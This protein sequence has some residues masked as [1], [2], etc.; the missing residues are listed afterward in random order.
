MANFKSI[1][2]GTDV[3][4]Q[5]LEKYHDELTSLTPKLNKCLLS[6]RVKGQGACF[7]DFEGEVVYCLIREYRPGIVYEISPDCGYSANYLL[8]AIKANEHGKLYSFEIETSKYNIPTEDIILGNLMISPND[9][10]FEL[11][12]GDASETVKNYPDPDFVLIDSCHDA[13]FAE[14]YVKELLP[15]IKMAALVQDIHFWDRPEYS[16]ESSFLLQHMQDSKKP[17]LA[18]GMAERLPMIASVRQ[19]FVPR[20][21][22][23]TNSILLGFGLKVENMLPLPSN[24]LGN[25][26]FDAIMSDAE[27]AKTYNHING[28]PKRPNAHRGYLYLAKVFKSRENH[29]EVSRYLQMVLGAAMA[30]FST[31][32]GKG[33]REAVLFLADNRMYGPLFRVNMVIFFYSPTVFVKIVPS[34]FFSFMNSLFKSGRRTLV[35]FVKTLSRFWKN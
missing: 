26:N 4:R 3:L 15:R 29:L 16:S 7:S 33:F 17:Y 31:D 22:F 19:D 28:L 35:W 18:L 34:V 24:P 25:M 11:I 13:W 21:P 8:A 9:S 5:L 23:E 1:T 12:F 30:S 32:K 14:W 6:M 27:I 10:E 20:Y 2:L